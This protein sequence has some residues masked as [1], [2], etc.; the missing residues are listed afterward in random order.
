MKRVLIL[1]TNAGQADII[2]YLKRENWEVHACA[3]KREGPVA[4][5]HII[6]I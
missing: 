5:W 4:T 3:Y 6:F 1:G 2:D